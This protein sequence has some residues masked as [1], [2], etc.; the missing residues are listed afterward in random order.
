MS[1]VPAVTGHHRQSGFNLLELLVA[2]TVLGFLVI[3]LN[4]GT[5]TGLQFW[6]VQNRQIARTAE[7]DTT[8]RLLRTLLSG[9]PVLPSAT[10]SPGGPPAPPSFAGKA[11]ELTFVGDL[12]NG[13]GGSQLADIKLTL[14]GQRLVLMWSPHRHE[15]A[16][17][18]PAAT[19]TELMSGVDRLQLGYWGPPSPGAPERW[20]AEWDGPPLPKLIRVHL[21]LVQGDNRHWPDL[22]VAPELWAPGA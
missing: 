15:L 11:G 12:P 8:A 14:H 20:L 1:T 22:I 13:L 21:I 16:G 10:A 4:Q 3:A 19:E 6:A 5:R 18:K 2:L 17:T 9:L 7:L